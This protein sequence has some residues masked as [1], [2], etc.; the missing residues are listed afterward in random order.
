MKQEWKYNGITTGV[1]YGIKIQWHKREKYNEIKKRE[2]QWGREAKH[3]EIRMIIQ[4][5][6]EEK[7]SEIRKRH[8]I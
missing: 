2:I 4:R 8:T 3:N 1:R 6:K 7:Y 5:N